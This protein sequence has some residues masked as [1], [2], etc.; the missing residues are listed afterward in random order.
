M[1][2]SL[3]CVNLVSIR[4]IGMNSEISI[5]YLIKIETGL[6]HEE[7][8]PRGRKAE[9]GRI[10]DRYSLVEL[11]TKRLPFSFMIF[12]SCKPQVSLHLLYVIFGFNR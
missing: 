9:E 10:A 11:T 1:D 4:I 3:S 2:S 6:E 8:V 12:P 7:Y 5:V